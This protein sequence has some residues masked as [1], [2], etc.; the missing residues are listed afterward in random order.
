MTLYNCPPRRENRVR[1]F[2]DATIAT[3]LTGAAD[4]RESIALSRGSL[5]LDGQGRRCNPED[6][7]GASTAGCI[8]LA[9]MAMFPDDRHDARD[10]RGQAE[11][12][13][14]NYIGYG[15]ETYD[16]ESA[17]NQENIAADIR[18]CAEAITARIPRQTGRRA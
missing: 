16:Q 10:A 4:L 8:R 18:N 15:I 7:T 13:F 12:A 14:Q 3:L 1:T 17:R 2:D 6:A 11:G 5:F 9:A